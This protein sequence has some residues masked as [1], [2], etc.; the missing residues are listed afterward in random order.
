MAKSKTGLI[1]IPLT[2]PHVF[3]IP[4]VPIA[5]PLAYD[6]RYPIRQTS[7]G[8]YSTGMFFPRAESVGC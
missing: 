6:I 7:E 1:L 3:T 4:C 5:D 2:K 8:K